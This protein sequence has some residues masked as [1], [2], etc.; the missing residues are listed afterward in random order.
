MKQSNRIYRYETYNF[1]HNDVTG[2]D[3]SILLNLLTSVAGES[4]VMVS[5]KLGSLYLTIIPRA[6]VGYQVIDSQRSA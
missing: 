3:S 6:R 1:S 2:K 4:F 5:L